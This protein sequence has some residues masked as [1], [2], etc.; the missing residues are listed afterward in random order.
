MLSGFHRV[1]NI[2]RIGH[3]DQILIWM[4]TD[5]TKI[6]NILFDQFSVQ[7]SNGNKANHRM[8]L[9]YIYIIIICNQSCDLQSLS[10]CIVITV[11]CSPGLLLGVRSERH[12]NEQINS[13]VPRVKVPRFRH[14][15]TTCN[16]RIRFR[17]G[18]SKHR[19]GI[20]YVIGDRASLVLLHVCTSDTIHYDVDGLYIG[21]MKCSM[22]TI[23]VVPKQ[24][25]FSTF[26]CYSFYDNVF[27]HLSYIVGIRKYA[28]CHWMIS[29]RQRL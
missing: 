13:Y 8:I 25:T 21:A 27:Y 4:I 17:R 29:E 6:V 15:D 20:H 26:V 5:L 11:C 2:C 1:R 12:K 23:I 28:F 7:F 18:K 10:G 16:E 14:E 19:F 9:D 22:W 24:N 3:A